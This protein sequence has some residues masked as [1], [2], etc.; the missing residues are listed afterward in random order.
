MRLRAVSMMRKVC[1]DMVK[2]PL[3]QYKFLNA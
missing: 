3:C 1:M 2:R